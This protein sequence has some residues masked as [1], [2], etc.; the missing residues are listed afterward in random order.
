MQIIIRAD[1]A[2]IHFPGGHEIKL[3]GIVRVT[4]NGGAVVRFPPRD[5]TVTEPIDTGRHVDCSDVLH[6]IIAVVLAGR[7]LADIQAIS[8]TTAVAVQAYMTNH[9][10]TAGSAD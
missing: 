10:L 1:G 5:V 4:A 3:P 9:G 6:C 8:P 7:P 2:Y